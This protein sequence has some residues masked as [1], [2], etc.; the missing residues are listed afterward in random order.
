MPAKRF[1]IFLVVDVTIAIFVHKFKTFS[2][3]MIEGQ[4]VMKIT[5]SP[6]TRHGGAWGRGGIAPTHS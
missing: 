3:I 1:N 6:A 2:K 5:C 4:K